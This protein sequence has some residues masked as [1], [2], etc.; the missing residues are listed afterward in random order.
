MPV[1]AD[2][3]FHSWPVMMAESPQHAIHNCIYRK[4]MPTEINTPQQDTTIQYPPTFVSK[5][6]VDLRD[7]VIKHYIR[8]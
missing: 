2:A 4:V 1:G 6:M 3:I 5:Y 7:D 8:I